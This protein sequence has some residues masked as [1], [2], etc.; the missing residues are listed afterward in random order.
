[1]ALNPDDQSGF[2]LP[3]AIH[4]D[5]TPDNTGAQYTCLLFKGANTTPSS[6]FLVAFVLENWPLSKIHGEPRNTQR[7]Q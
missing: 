6:P 3:L 2:T 5:V 4:G 7:I 1:M